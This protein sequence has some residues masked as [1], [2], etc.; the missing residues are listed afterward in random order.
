MPEEKHIIE[1]IKIRYRGFYDFE[2]V[3]QY[4]RGWLSGHGYK[5]HEKVF[6]E[7]PA[8]HMGKETELDWDAERKE[9]PFIKYYFGFKMIFGD[10]EGIEIV[11]NG[12]KKSSDKGKV[13]IIITPRI[14]YDWQQRYKSKFAKALLTILWKKIL[15]NEWKMKHEGKLQQQLSNLSEDLK[16]YLNMHAE[17]GIHY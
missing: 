5:L 4:L 16:K 6:K 7:K 15:Y 8:T 9:T 14:E 11:Q 10:R 2:K 1:P 13:E 12:E 3:Y 17:S